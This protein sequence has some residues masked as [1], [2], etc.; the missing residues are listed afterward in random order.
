[1]M[2][3]HSLRGHLLQLDQR[4]FGEQAEFGKF[5]HFVGAAG[6]GW[7]DRSYFDVGRDT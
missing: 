6:R 2:L 1:M 7:S 4:T 5:V 3:T